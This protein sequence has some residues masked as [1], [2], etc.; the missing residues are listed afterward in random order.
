M[1]QADDPAILDERLAALRERE[2]DFPDLR[3]PFVTLARAI[4]WCGKVPADTVAL[5]VSSGPRRPMADVMEDEERLRA[6]ELDQAEAQALDLE[7]G[8][9]LAYTAGPD[10]V[11]LDSRDPAAD[12]LAG[13]L[14]SM[15]VSTDL[16]TVRTEELGDEQYRYMVRVDWPRLN[17]LAERVGLPP[18]TQLLEET[19]PV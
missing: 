1:Y 17:D 8:L 16:A 2:S 5:E 3:R 4:V 11:S 6:V 15:L 7:N 10:D 12:R 14:I 18:V 13:A 9:R 19:R